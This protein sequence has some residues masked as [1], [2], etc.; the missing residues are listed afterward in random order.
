MYYFSL[1]I[2]VHFLINLHSNT[3]MKTKIDVL[4]ENFNIYSFEQS[5]FY[6]SILWDRQIQKKNTESKT[7]P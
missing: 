7:F 4:M 6:V 1:Y 5:S 3:Q 2:V